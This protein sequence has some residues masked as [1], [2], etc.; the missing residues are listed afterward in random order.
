MIPDYA[1][2]KESAM[3]ILNLN[4]RQS[5]INPE[6]N[7]GTVLVSIYHYHKTNFLR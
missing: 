4:K 1:K 5:K 3:R 6:D 2:G 7:T